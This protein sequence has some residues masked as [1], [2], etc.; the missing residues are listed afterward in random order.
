MLRSVEA[1]EDYAIRAADGDIGLVKDFFFDDK[2]WTVRYLIVETGS[3]L[4]HRQVLISPMSVGH[5]DW[6]ER[7][8][9]VTITKAQVQDS[10]LI[11]ARGPISRQHEADYLAYYG[12]P[13]Y[14]GGVGTWGETVG[15]T[16]LAQDGAGERDALAAVNA[17]TFRLRRCELIA[18]YRIHASDG[19]IGHVESFLMDMETWTL[20]YVIVNTSNW[21]LGHRAAIPVVLIAGVDWPNAKVSVRLSRDAVKTAPHYNPAPE[22]DRTY[23]AAIH[24]HYGCQPYWIHED[25]VGGPDSMW[26]TPSPARV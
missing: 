2:S 18:R 4:S 3:W 22:M 1:L 26:P 8:I 17:E 20:R 25:A 14:W 23:E 21:W 15:P 7:V 13:D 6:V 16:L 11:D 10:P 12:Y 24:T 19:D 9:P 5:T